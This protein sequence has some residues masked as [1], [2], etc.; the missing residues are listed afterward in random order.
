MIKNLFKTTVA[1]NSHKE[2]TTNPIKKALVEALVFILTLAIIAP[3]AVYTVQ[4]AFGADASPFRVVGTSMYPTLNNG[5]LVIVNKS[6]EA[7]VNGDIVVTQMP[8]AGRQYTTDEGA[9]FIVKRIIA[10][11]GETVDIGV[12]DTVMIDGIVI[13]EPY[14]TE[15]AKNETYVQNQTTHFELGNN[16]YFVVG[17]NRGNSC[18]SRYFGVVEYDAIAG[19]VNDKTMDSAF[20]FTSIAKYAIGI[21]I[22]YLLAEKILT[23]SLYKLFK[24]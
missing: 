12:D 17:D 3:I 15:T 7:Y 5:Q 9:H 21:I 19:V 10:S 4:F 23:V 16:Q 2:T 22:A 18:D 20:L 13:D 11:P 24:V 14:L 8:E 6:D 1:D